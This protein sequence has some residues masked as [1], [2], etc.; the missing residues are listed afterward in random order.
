MAVE[1]D[2]VADEA[3]TEATCKGLLVGEAFLAGIWGTCDLLVIASCNKILTS[4]C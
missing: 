4:S 2:G 3:P 1:A